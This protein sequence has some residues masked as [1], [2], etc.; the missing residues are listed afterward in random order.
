MKAIIRDASEV[1]L[2]GTQS[3]TYD[4]IDK[5]DKVLVSGSASGDVEQLIDQIKQTVADYEAKYKSTKRLK[6]GDEIN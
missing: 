1:E 2:N 6:V 3:V 4:I 5:N